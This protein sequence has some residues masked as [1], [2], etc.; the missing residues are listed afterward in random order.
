MLF[1]L[2]EWKKN[3]TEGRVMQQYILIGAGL[4]VL[5][6]IVGYIAGWF[7]QGNGSHYRYD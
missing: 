6:L 4:V 5:V 1:S 3:Q 2:I 7:S